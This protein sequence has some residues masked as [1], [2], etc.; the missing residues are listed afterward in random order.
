[1]EKNEREAVRLHYDALIDE[2]QDP[3][4]DPPQL[5]EYMDRWDGEAFLELLSPKPDD[6]VLEIGC[7]TGRLAA[8]VAPL[9]GSF[10]GID[11][12]PKTVA[13]AKKH[14]DRFGAEL[15]CDDFLSHP[16]ERRFDRIY[17]S[18]TMMHFADKRG[19]LEKIGSLLTEKGVCVLSL[20]KEQGRVLDYGTRCLALYPDSPDE[21]V[22]IL[23]ECGFARILVREIDFA[24]L[25]RA[26]K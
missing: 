15:I 25:I 21:T 3:V 11:L 26:E 20:D 24:F 9:V 2:G 6:S 16:F 18:L 19:V 13:V 10:C 14:L 23:R 4:C 5:Q 17:S 1:M 12:S 22:G 7:G 8:R